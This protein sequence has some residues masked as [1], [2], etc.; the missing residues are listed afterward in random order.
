MRILKETSKVEPAAG[1]AGGPQRPETGERVAW[2]CGTAR[3]SVHGRDRGPRH[4]SRPPACLG[5]ALLTGRARPRAP[6]KPLPGSPSTEFHILFRGRDPSSHSVS[7]VGSAGLKGMG[8]GG[9]GAGSAGTSSYSSRN[10]RGRKGTRGETRRCEGTF[11]GK[12]RRTVMA[13]TQEGST[14]QAFPATQ[15]R[16][17]DFTD[18]NLR[19]DIDRCCIPRLAGAQELL[20]L[21][22]CHLRNSLSI[23][24]L[25]HPQM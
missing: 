9:H 23:L 5:P 1:G 4:S 19:L 21:A 7:Q 8:V 13:Q 10:R 6:A 12:Q 18:L 24:A 15:R 16:G 2:T 11:T 14:G 22:F 3:S 25:C 20:G 17:T